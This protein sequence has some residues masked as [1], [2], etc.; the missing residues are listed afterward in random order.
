MTF[1]SLYC[2][3]S[4]PCVL[5]FYGVYRAEKDSVH[6]SRL[7]GTAMFKDARNDAEERIYSQINEKVDDFFEIGKCRTHLILEHKFFYN[8]F[9]TIGWLTSLC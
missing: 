4:F 2:Y 3:N 1:Y 9:N 8:T 7:R 5:T 6:A